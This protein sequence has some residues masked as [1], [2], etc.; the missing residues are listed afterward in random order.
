MPTVRS[1]LA[2]YRD[3]EIV[4]VDNASTDAMQIAQ[5][6]AARDPRVR[7]L[8][9]E[10]LGYGHENFTRCF[11]AASGELMAIY[12]ADDIYHP[13]IVEDEGGNGEPASRYRRGVTRGRRKEG[14]GARRCP[15]LF[16]FRTR[17]ST[18][19]RGFDFPPPFARCWYGHIFL[20]PAGMVHPYRD[21]PQMAP[22]Q[23]LA[24]PPTFLFSSALP[25]ATRSRS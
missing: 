14:A 17:F 19:I 25:A 1:I 5:D 10:E 13:T 4:I 7:H 11:V 18:A 15:V 24:G 6:F 12:H 22:I 21:E 23:T 8:R 9:F 16:R 2:H 3:I 20:T